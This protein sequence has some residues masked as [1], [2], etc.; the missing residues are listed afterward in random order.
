MGLQ[1]IAVGHKMPGWVEQGYDDY[2]R[3]FP[4]AQA[5]KLSEIPVARRQS[6]QPVERLQQQEADRIRRLR[7]PG[8]LLIAMDE[9]GRQ[10]SSEEWG[11]QYRRWQ[12]ERPNVD[13]LLGGP[14]GL[15]PSLLEEADIRLALGRMTLPHGLARVVLVEQ[16]YRAWSLS[17]GHP[18]HR[19]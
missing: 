12:R 14:D 1:I 2:A 5:V 11:E 9:H 7:Q 10:W 6:G 3:R 16:L 8:S 15:H 4:R 17:Q 13:F 18:Y 19:A